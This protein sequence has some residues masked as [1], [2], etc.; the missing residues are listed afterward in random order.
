M[1]IQVLSD[2]HL[3]FHPDGGKAFLRSL[4]PSGVDILL[5]AGDIGSEQLL[6]VALSSLCSQYPQ[7]IF[8]A[9]NHDYYASS[10]S[11]VEI[12]RGFLT[13][14]HKNLH[15]LENSI[16]EINGQRFV[17]TTLWFP[18]TEDA[19]RLS[20]HLNDF[21]HIREL[22]SWVYDKNRSAVS[23]L[24]DNLKAGDVVVTHHAPSSQGQDPRFRDDQALHCFYVCDVEPVIR[25]HRP[26]FWI[27]GHVH[28]SLDYRI[29]STRVLCNPFGYTGVVQNPGF[30]H[31]MLMDLPEP[32]LTGVL[33]DDLTGA[34]NGRFE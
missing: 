32:E 13:E 20:A 3:E 17:G 14:Q 34:V 33:S 9:G 10:L 22:N 21:D 11:D 24:S 19:R 18:E 29:G 27:H 7:V 28:A 5:V 6:P 26:A 25:Y 16:T 31:K 8:V 2:L 23:F 1:K 4:D 15:W 30:Q 12:L